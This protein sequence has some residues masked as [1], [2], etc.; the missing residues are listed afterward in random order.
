M[1]LSQRALA[2]LVI[3]A[4]TVVVIVVWARLQRRR[5]KENARISAILQDRDK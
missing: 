2:R 4:L 1:S 3:F 5:D